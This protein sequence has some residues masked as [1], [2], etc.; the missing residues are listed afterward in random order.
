[1]TR[2]TIW[3]PF[4]SFIIALTP[5]PF[6]E[7]FLFPY[8][9][10]SPP[11]LS[12]V[13]AGSSFSLQNKLRTRIS[14]FFIRRPKTGRPGPAYHPEQIKRQHRSKDS[15]VHKPTPI[16]LP[17]SDS[18]CDCDQNWRLTWAYH[19]RLTSNVDVFVLGGKGGNWMMIT[20]LSESL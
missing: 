12:K 13:W 5:S 1:M 2:K 15:P 6:V 14:I 4:F 17:F 9:L 19:N 11:P 20:D 3:P 7:N 16:I 18:G 8:S 10:S